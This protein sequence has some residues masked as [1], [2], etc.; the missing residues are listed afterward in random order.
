MKYPYDAVL[1]I[2]LTAEKIDQQPE[3]LGIKPYGQGVD[4]EVS[5]E[6]IKFY[7][8]RATVGMAAGYS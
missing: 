6:E 4:G 5:P 2:P 7:D 3:I 8:E 1:E